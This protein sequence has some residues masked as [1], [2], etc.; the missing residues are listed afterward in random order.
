MVSGVGFGED[1]QAVR[2]TVRV[3]ISSS[4]NML[5]LYASSSQFV[6]SPH[7]VS[8]GKRALVFEGGCQSG[9]LGLLRFDSLLC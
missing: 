2:K 8:F 9:P 5:S 1:G 4:F 3:W 7:I 6:A